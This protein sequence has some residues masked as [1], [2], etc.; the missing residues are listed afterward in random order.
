MHGDQGGQD[1]SPK[2]IKLIQP[3]TEDLIE[4]VVCPVEPTK[5]KNY[6]SQA[7]WL[8]GI[9][10][11]FTAAYKLSYANTS[12]LLKCKNLTGNTVSVFGFTPPRFLFKAL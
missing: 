11:I 8:A 9:A 10:Y 2:M 12:T 6:M 1:D 3:N 4:N 5:K 7:Y